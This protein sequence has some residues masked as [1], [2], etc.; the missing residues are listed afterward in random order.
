MVRYKITTTVKSL[1]CECPNGNKV[2][3]RIDVARG[4]V[5]GIKCPSAFNS[6]YPT[7]F[8]MKWRRTPVAKG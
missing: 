5:T 2:G 4:K 7:I 3:D 8:A 1:I 6:I